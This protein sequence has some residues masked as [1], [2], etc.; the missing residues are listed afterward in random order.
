MSEQRENSPLE[1]RY[2]SDELYIRTQR[3]LNEDMVWAVS[4]NAYLYLIVD[5]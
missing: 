4:F 3:Y 1:Y 5:I 2:G